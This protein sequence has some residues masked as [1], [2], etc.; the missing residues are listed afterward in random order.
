MGAGDDGA[1]GFTKDYL[2]L[3]CRLAFPSLV[4]WFKPPLS[5]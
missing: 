3:N 2:F 1:A 4:L 5:N